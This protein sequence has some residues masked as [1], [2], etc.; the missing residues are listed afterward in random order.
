MWNKHPNTYIVTFTTHHFTKTS[1]IHRQQMRVAQCSASLFS[2]EVHMNQTWDFCNKKSSFATKKSSQKPARLPILS[3]A[4]FLVDRLST[5]SFHSKH[6]V[7]WHCGCWTKNRETPQNGWWKWWKTLFSNGWFGSTT[8]F[9]NSHVNRQN[10][11]AFSKL[12]D[13]MGMICCKASRISS[14]TERNGETKIRPE[15]IRSQR[16]VPLCLHSFLCDANQ[17]LETSLLQVSRYQVPSAKIIKHLHTKFTTHLTFFHMFQ[18]QEVTTRWPARPGVEAMAI[19]GPVPI[20]RP[21]IIT[22]SWRPWWLA[23]FHSND[24]LFE[25]LNR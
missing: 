10:V 6:G 17:N 21:N 22:E 1:L 23:E 7:M 25:A 9:G 12:Q 4:L 20:E 8:I 3:L 19:A 13:H 5:R 11:F 14:W 16:W 2:M 24:R 18:T 15:Q